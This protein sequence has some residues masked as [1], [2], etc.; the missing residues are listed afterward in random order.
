MIGINNLSSYPESCLPAHVHLVDLADLAFP[1]L[2]I[3]DL[4]WK[5]KMA[6]GT[7]VAAAAA[8]AGAGAKGS[9]AGSSGAA[10]GAGPSQS[11]GMLDILGCGAG[12]RRH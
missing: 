6:F 9:I 2:Q 8:G 11:R 10:G 7:D 1:V 3:K 12:Y 4:G 5:I